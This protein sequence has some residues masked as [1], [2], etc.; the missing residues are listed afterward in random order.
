MRLTKNPYQQVQRAS[1]TPRDFELRVFRQVTFAMQ[2][3][4]KENDTIALFEL[5]F[6]G[7]DVS[8]VQERHYRLVESKDISGN[9][10]TAYRKT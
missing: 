4:Q 8:I 1:E 7:N 3:A 5:H 6:D 10:L 2:K 9:D